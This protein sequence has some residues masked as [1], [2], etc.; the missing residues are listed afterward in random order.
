MILRAHYKLI[1]IIQKDY[2]TSVYLIQAIVWTW[3][4]LINEAIAT[5]RQ[6]LF[7][8]WISATPDFMDLRNIIGLQQD[9]S[10]FPT[11]FTTKFF[12]PQYC[13]VVTF[14]G[15]LIFKSKIQ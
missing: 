13:I 9:N 4:W 12:T 2:K 5:S 15:V 6:G 3:L 11:N 7:L 14:P 10:L 8:Q 1:I